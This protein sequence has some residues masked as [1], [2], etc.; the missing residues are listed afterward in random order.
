VL[1]KIS[2]RPFEMIDGI[3]FFLSEKEPDDNIEWAEG[4]VS[5][6]WIEKN[7]N[8]HFNMKN[9]VR[10]NIAKRIFSMGGPILELGTSPGGGFMSFVLDNDIN[11]D[12]II[13]DLSP[14]VIKE[15]KRFFDK[16]VKPVNIKYAVLN[17]CDMPFKDE[18]LNVVTG[19]A[20]FGNIVGDKIKALNEIYRVLKHG[21]MYVA[22]DI[23]V[24]KEY[25]KTL[26]LKAYNVLIE[27]FPDMFMD[28]YQ[29][30]IDTGF[31][32]IENNIGRTWNNKND[33]S[34]LASLCREL[35]IYLEFSTY[36]RYCYKE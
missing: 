27:R 17:T 19:Y 15:W 8:E 6:N 24:N 11:A 29:E 20:A 9:D 22:G 1:N 32:K 16:N 2:N 30:S 23:C 21:G 10:V 18:T 33:E 4:L 12:I 14:T 35:G 34:V 13:S 5:G 3:A 28:Y 25:A 7:W 26:P 36:T 31:T